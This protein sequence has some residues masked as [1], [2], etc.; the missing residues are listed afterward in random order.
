MSAVSKQPSVVELFKALKGLFERKKC[1]F[2]IFVNYSFKS[3]DWIKTEI[4]TF[5]DQQFNVS[6]AGISQEANRGKEK[7]D[8]SLVISRKHIP[9]LIELKVLPTDRNYKSARGRFQADKHSKKDFQRVDKGERDFLIYVFWNDTNKWEKL[10]E[11][12]RTQYENVVLQD[13]FKFD[14]ESGKV[15]FSL[16]GKS[17]KSHIQ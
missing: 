14:L 3:E 4:V 9:I 8:L 10:K 12:L 6:F 17:K 1:Y 11:Y 5:W 7:P 2:N 15:V 16:W 13:E